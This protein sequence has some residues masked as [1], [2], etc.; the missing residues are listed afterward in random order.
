[1]L[2]SCLY[3]R[4]LFLVYV[5][6]AWI[7]LTTYLLVAHIQTFF[8]FLTVLFL[9]IFRLYLLN[10][11]FIVTSFCFSHTISFF[12]LIRLHL[13]LHLDSFRRLVFN[14]GRGLFGEI[15]SLFL[16]WRPCLLLV[17]VLLNLLLL[18][19]LGWPLV[20]LPKNNI[21]FL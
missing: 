15:G 4:F 17:Y 14:S 20:L 5:G 18:N 12:F 1:M 8:V 6:A 9:Q 21:S 7:S 11:A 13:L 2:S 10:D 3:L 16:I 19:L